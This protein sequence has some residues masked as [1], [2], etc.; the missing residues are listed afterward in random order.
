MLKQ[1]V[2]VALRRKAHIEPGGYKPYCVYTFMVTQETR[3]VLTLG[4][5]VK[6]YLP[7]GV[8]VNEKKIKLTHY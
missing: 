7:D 4:S 1:C 5:K 8:V 6:S 2:P 3:F